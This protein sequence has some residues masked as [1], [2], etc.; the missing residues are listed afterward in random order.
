MGS[1]DHKK[2]IVTAAGLSIYF[3]KQ[4]LLDNVFPICFQR[5]SQSALSTHKSDHVTNLLKALEWRPTVLGIKTKPLA[6]S[7]TARPLCGLSLGAGS[8][9]AHAL[10]WVSA[11]SP[12]PFLG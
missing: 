9:F 2:V 6:R 12:D 8:T 5:C 1:G 4:W 3:V 10:L 11:A 7:C